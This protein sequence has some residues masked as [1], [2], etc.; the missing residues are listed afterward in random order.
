[1]KG[2][3]KFILYL[4]IGI[5]G[6]ITCS[7]GFILIFAPDEVQLTTIAGISAIITG[8]T[9]IGWIMFHLDKLTKWN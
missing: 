2:W 8:L 9:A 6:L 1:M 5:A 4:I 7:V 3:Q